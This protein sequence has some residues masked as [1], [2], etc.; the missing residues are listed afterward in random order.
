MSL[1]KLL[2]YSSDLAKLSHFVYSMTRSCGQRYATNDEI[3]RTI[4][5]MTRLLVSRKG[6]TLV[7]FEQLLAISKILLQ[8]LVSRDESMTLHLFSPWDTA[9]ES[10]RVLT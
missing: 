7:N 1:G 4:T 5:I 6:T 3:K 9:G 10:E 2:C 8:F